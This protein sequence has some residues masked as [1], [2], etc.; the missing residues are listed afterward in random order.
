MTT[1][2]DLV[3][4]TLRFEPTPRVPR[5][6]W[7]LPWAQRHYPDELAAIQR[8]FPDDFEAPRINYPRLPM[9]RGD[10]CEVGTFVD[11]WGC[12]FENVQAGVIGEVKAPLL[13]SY[14]SDLEKLRPPDEWLRA[15][16]SEVDRQ[17]EQSDRFLLASTPV[18]LFERMQF[19]RGT[20]NLLMDLLEQPAGLLKLRDTVHAWN[21]AMLDRWAATAVDGIGWMDDWGSQR[22][23]LMN[24]QLWR[25]FFKPCYRA[26]VDRIHAA[27]KFCFVHSDGHIMSVYEDLIEIGVDAINSQL[28]CMDIEEIGQRFKGRIAF[29]GE[30]DRQR[31]LSSASVEEVRAAVRRV[32]EALYDGQGGVIA[33]CEF[34]AGARPANVRAVFEE[35][36]RASQDRS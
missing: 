15:D 14:A 13:A 7:Y 19:L 1:S 10:P 12:V 22:A 18:R 32:A 30:I 5:N 24:P 27:G 11:E 29:W 34:G 17:Y 21:L 16:L 28:F 20:E 2:R 36:A 4:R 3:R 6:L 23:L 25:E 8:D 31:I 26:Y 33:Q 9:M 35:W